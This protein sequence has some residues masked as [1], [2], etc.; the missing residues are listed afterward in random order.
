MLT[1]KPK[2]SDMCN[3]CLREKK[4]KDK[5]NPKEH[6]NDTGEKVICENC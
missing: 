5:R 1:A 2:L 4:M 3:E 6:L